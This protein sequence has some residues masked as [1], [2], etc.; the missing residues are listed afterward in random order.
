VQ[1]HCRALCSP[2]IVP[3]TR[4]IK[5]Y[6]FVWQTLW[7]VGKEQNYFLILPSATNFMLDDGAASKI[8]LN[9]HTSIFTMDMA[10]K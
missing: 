1:T 8:R 6:L 5:L 10:L 7:W 3:D 4:R 9:S 2:S